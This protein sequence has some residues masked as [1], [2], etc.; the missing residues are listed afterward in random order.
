MDAQWQVP[1]KSGHTYHTDLRIMCDDRD[2]LLADVTRV[3]SEEKIKVT[4]LNVS[5][6][7]G[8]AVFHISLEIADGE[9]LNQLSQRLLR[10]KSVHEISRA[11][12]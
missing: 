5:T 6:N 9:R 7:Q 2:G 3:F 10:E 1:E 4:R 12:S 8:S 11:V